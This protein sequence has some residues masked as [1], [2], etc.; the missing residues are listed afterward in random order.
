MEEETKQIFHWRREHTG[1]VKEERNQ[2][3]MGRSLPSKAPLNQA[4]Q[5]RGDR[6]KER[7]N[8]SQCPASK[9]HPMYPMYILG[10]SGRWF[11]SWWVGSLVGKHAVLCNATAVEDCKLRKCWDISSVSCIHIRG[12]RAPVSHKDYNTWMHVIL[13]LGLV[14]VPLSQSW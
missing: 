10:I 11:S 2:D 12:Q 6:E 4:S 3:I 7:Q 13:V 5:G 14:A 8:C 9:R 1:W